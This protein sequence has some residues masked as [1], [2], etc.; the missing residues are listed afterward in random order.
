[1]SRTDEKGSLIIV[2]SPH[3]QRRSEVLEYAIDCLTALFDLYVSLS[4]G[5]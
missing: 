4:D 1:M 3:Q 2:K 5:H